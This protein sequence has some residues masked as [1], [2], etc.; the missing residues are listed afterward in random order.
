MDLG[1]QVTEEHVHGRVDGGR[2]RGSGQAVLIRGHASVLTVMAA[3]AA[4]EL[5]PQAWLFP[6]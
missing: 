4:E 6:R 1:L 5:E 2:G 3:V